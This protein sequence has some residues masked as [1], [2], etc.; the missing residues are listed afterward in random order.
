[1]KTGRKCIYCYTH[2]AGHYTALLENCFFEWIMINREPQLNRWRE[3]EA[4][5]HSV[6]KETYLFYQ[7]LISWQKQRWTDCKKWRWRMTPRK[8]HLPDTA[9]LMHINLRGLWQ[10]AEDLHKFKPDNAPALSRRGRQSPRPNHGVLFAIN[11]WLQRENQFSPVVCH[12]VYQPHSRSGPGIFTGRRLGSFSVLT[13]LQA[14]SS[15]FSLSGFLFCL[16]QL[17]R[18]LKAVMWQDEA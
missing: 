3:C 2:R 8:P 13:D 1:M 17:E 4:L 14:I 7:T 15:T 12:W 9:E 16:Q 18:V 6:L 10:V 11:T 5:E